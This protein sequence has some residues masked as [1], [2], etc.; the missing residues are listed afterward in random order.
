MVPEFQQQ[1]LRGFEASTSNTPRTQSYRQSFSLPIFC[2]VEVRI[3]V[4]VT[5]WLG[6]K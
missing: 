2:T 6:R 4:A 1:N 5:S 3:A